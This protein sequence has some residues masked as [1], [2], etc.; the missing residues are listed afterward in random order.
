MRRIDDCDHEQSAEVVDD[1][2]REQ[3]DAQPG[4]SARGEQRERTEGE[5][6]VGRHRRPPGVRTGSARV[7]REVDR[8]GHRH[9]TNRS[10]H[11]RSE[12]SPLAQLAD[13]E[14]ALGLEPDD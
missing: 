10:D 2:E 13:V 9:P 14:L 8:D 7:E 4:G 1:G 3:E 6:R 5:S 12:P 11:R